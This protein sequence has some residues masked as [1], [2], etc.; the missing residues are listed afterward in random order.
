[1]Y[2]VINKS[3]NRLVCCKHYTAIHII[4]VD[5]WNFRHRCSCPYRFI[6][7]FVT[8]EH[9]NWSNDSTHYISFCVQYP[10]EFV[11]CV[12]DSGRKLFTMHNAQCTHTQWTSKSIWNACS[13]CACIPL[14][15]VFNSGRNDWSDQP[16]TQLNRLFEC[17]L[18]YH[19]L[20]FILLPWRSIS[21]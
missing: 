4:G 2:N 14:W 19:F 1:M 3:C 21:F 6:D 16:T 18:P 15:E 17:L 9:W 13:M 12:S 11:L 8:N 5:D 7:N 10:C 20:F